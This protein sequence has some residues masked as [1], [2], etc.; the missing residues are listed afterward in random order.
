MLWSPEIG[1]IIWSYWAGVCTLAA[2]SPYFNFLKTLSEHGKVKSSER[3]VPADCRVHQRADVRRRNSFPR[4]ASETF[5][6]LW[7]MLIKKGCISK[8]RFIDFYTF[9]ILWTI[10]LI[11]IRIKSSNIG[12][13]LLK[14]DRVI[15]LLVFFLCHALRRFFEQLYLFPKLLV[16]RSGSQ[17]HFMAYLLGIT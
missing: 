7:K 11:G 2:V 4:M 13:K 5:P 9:A 14:N 3:E 8:Y 12:M 16:V 6:V 1:I 15:V 10:A 17:M